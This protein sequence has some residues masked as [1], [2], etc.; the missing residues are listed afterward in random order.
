MDA[1]M[2]PLAIKSVR[3]SSVRGSSFSD[4]IQ[5]CPLARFQ[6]SPSYY[7]FPRPTPCGPHTGLLCHL[8]L[9]TNSTHPSHPGLPRRV[10][11][12]LAWIRGPQLL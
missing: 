9:Y 5:G 1:I 4:S 11:E 7:R 8:A 2:R 10:P 6:P 12:T 3:A